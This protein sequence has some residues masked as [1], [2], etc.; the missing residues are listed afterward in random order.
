M[1]YCV[2]KN[3]YVSKYM[4]GRKVKTKRNINNAVSSKT[5][6][7]NLK[8]IEIRAF[9]VYTRTNREEIVKLERSPVPASISIFFY[10][11]GFIA[12]L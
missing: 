4:Y 2:A 8:I 10:T 6:P 9:A 1:F 3:V 12:K 5:G 7:G 11:A